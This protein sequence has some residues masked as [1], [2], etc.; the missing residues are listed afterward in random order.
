[1]HL[2]I[3]LLAICDPVCENGGTCTEPDTCECPSEYSG[4]QCQNGMFS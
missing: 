1:M 3:T 2:L 4:E